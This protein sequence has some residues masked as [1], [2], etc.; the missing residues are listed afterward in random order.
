MTSFQEL[1]EVLARDPEVRSGTLVFDGTRVPVET[2]LDNLESGQTPEEFLSGHP[3]ALPDQIRT[4]ATAWED[5]HC[6]AESPDAARRRLLAYADW[7]L[8]SKRVARRIDDEAGEAQ[9]PPDLDTLTAWAE[10]VVRDLTQRFGTAEAGQ[11]PA[12]RPEECRPSRRDE[13]ERL[14]DAILTL[15]DAVSGLRTAGKKRRVLC[16]LARDLAEMMDHLQSDEAARAVDE[17][18]GAGAGDSFT[19]TL[20]ALTDSASALRMAAENLQGCRPVHAAHARRLAEDTDR[21][22]TDLRQAGES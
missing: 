3:T 14:A 8:I 22:I 4:V 1:G 9:T 6:D 18:F 13:A 7:A 19:E 11:G 20:H 15:S 17:L 10:D 12:D 21:L 5:I 2:L 16:P